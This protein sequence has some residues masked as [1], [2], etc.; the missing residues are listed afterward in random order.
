MNKQIQRRAL[1][2]GLGAAAVLGGCMNSNFDNQSPPQ[3]GAARIDARVAQTLEHMQ[4]TYPGTQSLVQNSVAMLVMP[5]VTEAGFGFGGAYGRGA[6]LQNGQTVDYYSATSVS[7]GL[8][9]GGKQ[10]SHV[11]FFMT[12]EA[13]RDFR[14]SNGWAAGAN[15]E[16]VLSSEGES[17][18]TDTTTALSPVVAAVFAQAGFHVGATL[19]GI[20]YTRIAPR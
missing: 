11:L 7:A 17:L 10:Y 15:I 19:E 16:Y 4:L 20:K 1:L 13:A 5:L 6:L 2:G 9:I 14:R 3:S 12:A 18:R 8:Q